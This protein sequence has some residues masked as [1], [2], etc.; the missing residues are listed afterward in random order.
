MRSLSEDFPVQ[1]HGDKEPAMWI[2]KEYAKAIIALVILG[3]LLWFQASYEFTTLPASAG[4]MAPAIPAN[5]IYLLDQSIS[6][7]SDLRHED[8]VFFSFR[9]LKGSKTFVSRVAGL[10]GERIAIRD[11]K[12][13]RNGEAVDEIYLPKLSSGVYLEE[14]T[15]PRGYLYVLNDNRERINDSRSLGPLPWTA[16]FGRT[17]K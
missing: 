3:A 16:V 10:P 14:I 2:V 15:V 8:I 17:R 13:F 4:Q 5:S 11:G 6:S 9:T 1:R 7:P 12:L